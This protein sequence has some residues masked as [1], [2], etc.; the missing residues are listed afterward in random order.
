M[1]GLCGDLWPPRH[2]CAMCAHMC[3]SAAQTK[4]VLD[5]FNV[6]KQPG[7]RIYHV[8]VQEKHTSGLIFFGWFP[9]EGKK[10][11][12][13]FQLRE[14]QTGWSLRRSLVREFLFLSEGSWDSGQALDWLHIHSTDTFIRPF[15]CLDSSFIYRKSPPTNLYCVK[16]ACFHCCSFFLSLA[17]AIHTWILVFHPQEARGCLTDLFQCAYHGGP[18]PVCSKHPAT[19]T[20]TCPNPLQCNFN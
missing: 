2:K 19:R 7:A 18:P 9:V 3:T 1:V 11:N 4:E 16:W 15:P 6:E 12:F 20:V 17:R 10:S 13:C 5:P 14:V 8:S